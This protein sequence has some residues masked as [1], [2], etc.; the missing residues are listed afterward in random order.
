MQPMVVVAGRDC[1]YTEDTISYSAT[2]SGCSLP[3]VRVVAC[4]SK[5]LASVV[6]TT[7]TSTT[8]RRSE[9]EGEVKGQDT[10]GCCQPFSEL[11][12][13]NEAAVATT[14]CFSLCV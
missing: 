3:R 14:H 2:P 5:S 4:N 6:F 12:E 9:R 8:S 7:Q 11:P 13:S 1:G 10:Q